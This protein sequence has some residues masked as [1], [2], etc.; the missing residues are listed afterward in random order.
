MRVVIRE[1]RLQGSAHL[2]IAAPAGFAFL[3]GRQLNTFG[4]V[5]CYEHE[6]TD[7]IGVYR[8]NLAMST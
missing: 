2:F 4:K 7:P 5:Y 8:N 3:L 1:A 6:A